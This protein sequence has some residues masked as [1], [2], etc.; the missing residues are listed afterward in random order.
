[1]WAKHNKRNPVKGAPASP[2]NKTEKRPCDNQGKTKERQKEKN[3]EKQMKDKRKTKETVSGRSPSTSASSSS[4]TDLE[5]LNAN[6]S[7]RDGLRKPQ[8]TS[9]RHECLPPES[10][11]YKRKPASMQHRQNLGPADPPTQSTQHAP[12]AT[13]RF[14]PT[15]QTRLK[16]SF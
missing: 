2:Y 15:F 11:H 1:M 3:K 4:P 5:R 10:C 14:Q 9:T 16:A 12:Q 13:P 7:S 8:L 6:V